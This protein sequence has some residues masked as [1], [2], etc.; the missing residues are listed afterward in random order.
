VEIKV[1]KLKKRQAASR[2]QQWAMDK[3][4]VERK[5]RVNFYEVLQQPSGKG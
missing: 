2:R 3:P 5:N 4:P 1:N